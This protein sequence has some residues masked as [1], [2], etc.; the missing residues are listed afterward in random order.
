MIG[1]GRLLSPRAARLPH[2]QPHALGHGRLRRIRAPPYQGTT[3]GRHHPSQTGRRLQR[4]EKTPTPERATE[5]VQ[6]ARQR[7]SE[8][9]CGRPDRRHPQGQAHVISKHRNRFIA[10]GLIE[11]V[12]YGKVDFAIPGLRQYLRDLVDG[13][14]LIGRLADFDM[15][16][17]RSHELQCSGGTT[18]SGHLRRARVPLDFAGP[19]LTRPRPI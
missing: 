7:G 1:C 8:S 5:P 13:R 9:L 14:V 12:G 10:A 6:R 17:R 4:A 15:L 11:S 16:S 18:G 19:A 2:S 3:T